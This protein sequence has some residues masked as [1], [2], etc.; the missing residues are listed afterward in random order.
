MKLRKLTSIALGA[1]ALSLCVVLW[2]R[3]SVAPSERV[4]LQVHSDRTIL[5]SEIRF[6]PSDAVRG[7]RLGASW[8]AIERDPARALTVRVPDMCP[9]ALAAGAAPRVI[10]VRPMIE[11]GGDRAQIG[12]GAEFAIDVV[13]GCA[14]G[15]R[16][17]VTWRQ[18]EGPPL[19]AWS[20]SAD[21]FRLR[22]RTQP[23]AALH[24]E[25]FSPGIVPFAPRT[26]GRYVLEALW[27]G[28]GSPAVRRRLTITSI[29]RASGVPNLAVTQQVLLGGAGWHVR[30]APRGGHAAVHAAQGSLGLFA[31]D[32]PGRWSL[33]DGSG[34]ELSIQ[35]SWHDKTPLDCG[36]GECHASAARAATTSPMSHA[37]ERQ[38]A[39]AASAP[40]AISCA[41]DCH[42]TGERGLHDGGFSDVAAELGWGWLG[43]PSWQELP[44]VLRRLG[45][46][47]CMSCHGPGAIPEPSARASILRSDVCATCH[48]APP[49]YVHVMQWRASRMARSD[50]TEATRADACA[51]CHT[52]AGF[53][54]ALGVRKRD[55]AL[56]N[57][58]PAG[59]A[60]AA[61]HAPHALQRGDKLIRSLP[62]AD[63]FGAWDEPALE[64]RTLVCTGCHAPV[65]ER[66]PPSASSAAIWAGRVRV[67]SA[68]TAG[69]WELVRAKGDH[70]EVAGGCIGC[71]GGRHTE[72]GRA[73]AV[74]HS[75]HVD[76]SVC[77]TCHAQ[78][79]PAERLDAQQRSVRERALALDAELSR[80]CLPPSAAGLVPRH[81]TDPPSAC[82]SAR[83]SSALYQVRLV[84]EDP[85]AAVHNARFARLLLDNAAGLLAVE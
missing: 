17:S 50:V 8:L 36:R 35:A 27:Q 24:P 81:A 41:L 31:P 64:A 3:A 22:A 66:M 70:R 69:A 30:R 65:D 53:L 4:V 20:P 42:V 52:T 25:P 72:A 38:F 60:C 74:D 51:R 14:D 11:L 18:L 85:A 23:L 79:A 82:S 43:R 28:A 9:V 29:A 48:D 37:F 68:Q 57:A 39:L 6:E 77:A 13:R 32:A 58:E 84:L 61:C 54:A 62:P 44:Q 33:E 63:A 75:F 1:L 76:R 2:R 80:R 40:D 34:R 19:E 59:I 78:Q 73:P 10:Q 67:P 15:G 46:V 47:R 71:H 56:A 5:A 7:A 49:R 45:G 16:G 12:F 26:Q 83:L 55:D 21:G